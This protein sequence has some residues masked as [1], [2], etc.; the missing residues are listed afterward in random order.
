MECSEGG[1]G[2]VLHGHVIS[3]RPGSLHL[4]WV[5]LLYSESVIHS[6]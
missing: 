2:G 3:D 1:T 6:I 5:L 4:G